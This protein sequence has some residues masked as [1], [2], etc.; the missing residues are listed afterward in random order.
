MAPQSEKQVAFDRLV[1]EGVSA[2]GNWV[3]VGAK[4]YTDETILAAEA[5][6]IC[7]NREA[8]LEKEAQKL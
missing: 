1:D 2:G 3:A 4:A 8:E 5:T 7:R 6:R